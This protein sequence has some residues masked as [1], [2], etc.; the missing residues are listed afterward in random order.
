MTFEIFLGAVLGVLS[1]AY[2]YIVYDNWRSK[3]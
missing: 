1:V 3:K 2:G